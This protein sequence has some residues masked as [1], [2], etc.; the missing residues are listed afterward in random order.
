MA[1]RGPIDRMTQRR[2]E[3]ESSPEDVPEEEP[4]GESTATEV[5]PGPPEEP[6]SIPLAKP[7][8]LLEGAS[9]D[10]LRKRQDAWYAERA[11]HEAYRRARRSEGSSADE[12][13]R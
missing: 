2:L 5:E 1:E 8:L 4:G 11:R 3:D 6:P 9:D 13:Q 10:N 7:P 12:A